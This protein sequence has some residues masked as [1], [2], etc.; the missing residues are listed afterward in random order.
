LFDRHIIPYQTRLLSPIARFL[1]KKGAT[2][3]WISLLGF[4][5]GLMVVLLIAISSFSSALACAVA[6]LP[7]RGL[8]AH[9]H[10]ILNRAVHRLV[11][12]TP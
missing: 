1:V 10:S 4:G 11:R 7:G 8:P 2:A 9:H 12:S 6:C 5:F 3:D